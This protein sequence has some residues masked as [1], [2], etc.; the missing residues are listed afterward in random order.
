[1]SAIES[2]S[3]NR[4][5]LDSPPQVDRR[6]GEPENGRR[7]KKRATA[8]DAGRGHADPRALRKCRTKAL[9]PGAHTHLDLAKGGPK[10][11]GLHSVR[12]IASCCTQGSAIHARRFEW[13]RLPPKTPPKRRGT[14]A[15]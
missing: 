4:S 9:A 1:M 6:A 14:R 15:I 13:Q 7:S 10:M 12:L 5:N 3:G 8:E 2:K 11:W